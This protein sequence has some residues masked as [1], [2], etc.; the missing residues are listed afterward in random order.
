[1]INITSASAFTI[2]FTGREIARTLGFTKSLQP[3]TTSLTGS[4]FVNFSTN[5]FAYNILLNNYVTYED[6]KSNGY[7]FRVPITSN[8][9]GY[10]T[11]EP[12]SWTQVVEIPRQLNQLDIK[13]YDDQHNI[14]D[15][16]LID[17][18]IHLRRV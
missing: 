7:T 3:S 15:L 2:D 4:G 11:Y 9:L 6:N 16:N 10:T 17:W 14:V 12:Q 5:S 1:V 18:Y 8:S 13:V